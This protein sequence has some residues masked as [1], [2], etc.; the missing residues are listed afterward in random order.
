M[1][2]DILDQMKVDLKVI[3]NKV[4][5]M[6][7]TMNNFGKT[8]QAID[9]KEQPEEFQEAA[10]LYSQS[11]NQLTEYLLIVVDDLGVALLDVIEY[12]QSSPKQKLW[13]P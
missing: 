7:T 8:L 3:A 5:Q 6:V 1:D 13:V 2:N 11:K 10:T 9:S 12:V 4:M